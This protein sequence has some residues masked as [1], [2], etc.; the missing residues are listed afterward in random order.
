MR[1][2][3]LA[4]H[5]MFMRSHLGW[6]SRG[7]LPHFDSG[8]TTQFV[9]FRLA[10]SLP[11]GKIEAWR[12]ELATQDLENEQRKKKLRGRI[13]KFLDTGFG[14]CELSQPPI[15]EVVEHTMLHFDEERYKMVSWVIMPNHVH[16]LFEVHQ[17]WPLG[18]I[19]HSWKSFSAQQ[20]ARMKGPR[21]H[22]WQVD[23][24]D[25]YMRDEAHLQK[26]IGYI[27]NNPVKAGLCATPEA[28]PYGSA[29]FRSGA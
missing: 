28:W 21:G 19:L 16:A 8:E 12:S 9:T 1:A 23:Y 5:F 7:Y 18:I 20:V 26:A 27:E 14:G 15:A 25:R 4:L 2:G 6:H 17:E 13:E 3:M 11:Q 29:R 10:D 22:F 24:F